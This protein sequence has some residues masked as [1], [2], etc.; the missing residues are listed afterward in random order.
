M[1]PSLENRIELLE[2]A[3]SELQTRQLTATI[4][5]G[6]GNSGFELF[7]DENWSELATPIQ[8]SI[9]LPKGWKAENNSGTTIITVVEKPNYQIDD[10]SFNQ[11]NT[12]FFGFFIFMSG[13]LVLGLFAYY[14]KQFL[15]NF[16]FPKD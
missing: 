11:I 15:F 4:W 9:T 1:D 2:S 3:I 12:L 14:I 10:E 16:L 13:V 8:S 5:Q 7:Y 6:T